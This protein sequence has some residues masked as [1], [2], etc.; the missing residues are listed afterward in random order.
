MKSLVYLIFSLF[1]VSALGALPE[2][3]VESAPPIFVEQEDGSLVLEHGTI[4]IEQTD[5]YII[6]AHGTRILKGGATVLTDKQRAIQA[7]M[8]RKKTLKERVFRILLP[9]KK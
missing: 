8:I 2:G 5:G 1:T 4:A 7:E 6:L 9:F 3:S